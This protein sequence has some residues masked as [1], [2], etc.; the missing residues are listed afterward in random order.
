M[1]TGVLMGPVVRRAVA[2]LALALLA[3][4]WMVVAGAAPQ[5]L[6]CDASSHCHAYAKNL[7]TATNHGIYGELNAHCLYQPANHNRAT[8]EIWD[9]DSTENHWV[10]AGV[11]SGIDYHGVYRNKNWYWADLRPGYNYAEHDKS[12][13]ASTNHDY[14][15]RIVFAGVETWDVIGENSF[16][17]M[18]ASTS[19]RATLVTGL[20]GTE[21]WGSSTSGIRDQGNIYSLERKSS[22][23][24]WYLWGGNAKPVDNGSNHYITDHYVTGSHTYWNGPC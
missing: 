2:A 17:Y 18:G 19:N 12:V 22:G 14:P 16:V 23:N 21:Y 8:N 13:T 5:A 1:L 7:N 11:S 24:T 20:A 3:S 9:T 6:A 15:V 10:E 4:A